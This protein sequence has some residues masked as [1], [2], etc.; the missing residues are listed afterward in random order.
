MR[1]AAQPSLARATPHFR[2]PPPLLLRLTSF[3]ISH[4]THPT[5]PASLLMTQSGHMISTETLQSTGIMLHK[6]I[7]PAGQPFVVLLA[8]GPSSGRLRW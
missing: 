1:A 4:P 6:N 3:V 5:H 7:G 2:L 8:F